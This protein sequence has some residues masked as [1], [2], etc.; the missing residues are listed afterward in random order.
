MHRI[1]SLASI[2]VVFAYPVTPVDAALVRSQ[3]A[4]FAG[5]GGLLDLYAGAGSSAIGFGDA[6]VELTRPDGGDGFEQDQIADFTNGFTAAEIDAWLDPRVRGSWTMVGKDGTSEWFDTTP[7]YRSAA[8]RSYGVLTASSQA[9][10]NQIVAERT[11]GTFTFE[12]VQTVAELG[13][14]AVQLQILGASTA[15]ILSGRSF[16]VTVDG[17]AASAGGLLLLSGFGVRGPVIGSL[18]T[19]VG[20]DEG[21]MTIYSTAIPAPGGLAVLGLAGLRSRRRR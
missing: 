17:E 10:W 2:V 18:G 19:P 5:D 14:S 11:S 21:F 13:C 9:L 7:Q 1:A 16:T 12:M 20:V 4:R 15:T 8:E 6:I 3:V